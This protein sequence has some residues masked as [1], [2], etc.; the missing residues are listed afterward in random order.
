M[1]LRVGGHALVL[2]GL[3]LVDGGA[4]AGLEI[5]ATTPD[6]GAVARAIG[7]SRVKVTVLAKPTED[8]HF[9][10][11]KPSHIVGLNR[12]DA[13]VESGAE[14]ELGW[15]PPLVEG[16]RNR[17]VLAGAR[18]RFLGASGVEL[19]DMPVALDRSRGD[20]HA[21]GNP[22]FLMDPLN[23][24][25]VARR[26]AETFCGLD[27]GSCPDYRDNLAEFER[28][29]EERMQ[30]WRARLA[31]FAGASIVT[32]HNTWRYFARRFE[33]R[34]DT[35]LEPKPGIPPSPP[36]LQKVIEEMRAKGMKVILVEPFQSRR[37]AETVAA[38]TG[39][40]VVDVCQFPG[41]LPGTDQD[42]FALMDANVDA[43]AGALAGTVASR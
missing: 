26:L 29:L 7:G 43:I 32:Y 19:L 23:T 1:K 34:A 11:A 38:H 5:V 14:L 2:L 37:T 4:R 15:L 8:P 18:G 3:A 28:R 13:L 6:Y 22:H 36:H 12:A 25:I 31:P 16:A 35:F 21:R 10:D 9:V 39:A 41:G 24:G 27:P 40:M 20:V 30:A 42:Y 33:L 17:N